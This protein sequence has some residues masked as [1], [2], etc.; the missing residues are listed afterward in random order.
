MISDENYKA[1]MKECDFDDYSFIYPHNESDSCNAAIND[2]NRAVT[3][4]INIYDVI[5]DVC[6][7]SIVEQELRLHKVVCFI[8]L[9]N[10]INPMFY[11]NHSVL[12][13]VGY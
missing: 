10:Y 9:F 2:E 3:D 12:G 5:V 6:Y 7:P 8:Y 13:F 4:Y 1:I 11:G